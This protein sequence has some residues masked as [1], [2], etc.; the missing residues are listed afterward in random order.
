MFP[1]TKRFGKYP[2]LTSCMDNFNFYVLANVL[3]GVGMLHG[4]SGAFHG[5]MGVIQVLAGISPSS[6]TVGPLASK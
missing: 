1:S 5:K 2:S 3:F 4:C 6:R